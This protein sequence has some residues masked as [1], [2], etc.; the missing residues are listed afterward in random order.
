M[1]RPPATG[2][3]NRRTQIVAIGGAL[4]VV[5]S[6]ALPR[7]ISPGGNPGDLPRKGR[8]QPAT[9]SGLLRDRVA[10]AT[11]PHIA[12]TVTAN[13][14][15]VRTPDIEAQRVDVEHVAQAADDLDVILS[16]RWASYPAGSAIRA[17]VEIANRDESPVWIPSPEEPQQTLSIRVL[18]ENGVTV[19]HVVEETADRVPHRMRRLGPGESTKIALDVLAHGEDALPPGRYELTAVYEADKAWLR[20]GLPVWSAPKGARHSGRV[21]FEVTAK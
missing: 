18:D 12:P 2:F 10:N 17:N 13:E 19:R 11:T 16:L 3:R 1:A 8:R 21:P 6:L 9:Q 7:L 14:P 5:A 15:T 20:T 4:V